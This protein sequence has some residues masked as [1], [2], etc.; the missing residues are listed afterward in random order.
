MFMTRSFMP[1]L[2]VAAGL[3]TF[4]VSMPVAAQFAKPEDA[5]RYRR[6]AF[7]VMSTH[8]GRVAAMAN[9]KVPF[10]A[11]AVA[12]NAEIATI[13]SKLPYAGFVEG[14]DKG[15]TKAEP[16]IWTEMDKFRAAAAHMQDEMVKLNVV[17]KTGNVDAI[18]A[19]V[20]ETGKACKACHDDYRK[21]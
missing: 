14:S 5:I 9:G 15:D 8:F 19:A 18:K 6:A 4:A 10:D 16:K 20:G 1:M 2:M 21:Q 7:T 12:D 17:A 11:K 3:A 13:M